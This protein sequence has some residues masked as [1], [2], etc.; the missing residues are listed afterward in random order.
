MA[1]SLIIA[2]D[3]GVTP[4]RAQE[5]LEAQAAASD[6]L[7]RL[8]GL[9]GD[10][11]VETAFG[12]EIEHADELTIYVVDEAAVEKAMSL[13]GKVGLDPDKTTVEVAVPKPPESPWD[14]QQDDPYAA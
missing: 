1:R 7:E 2:R 14:W 3:A 13:L 8:G 9:L 10:D 4:A 6:A 12:A 5:I 11:F